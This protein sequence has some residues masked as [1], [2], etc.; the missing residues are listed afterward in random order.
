MELLIIITLVIVTAFI[1]NNVVWVRET[2]DTIKHLE[3]RI[4]YLE[5]QLNNEE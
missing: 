4:Y 3:R 1:I 2:N 5:K